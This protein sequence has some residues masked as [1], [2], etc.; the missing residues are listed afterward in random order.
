MLFTCILY[1]HLDIMKASALL[2]LLLFCSIPIYG[3]DLSWGHSTGGSQEDLPFALHVDPEDNIYQL[4][5][6]K[7]T[8]DADPG[9]DTSWVNAL[10]EGD[11]LIQ[12]FNTDGQLLWA[13]HIGSI[14]NEIPRAITGDSDGNIWI[15]GIFR[16]Q[17]DVDPGVGEV[18]LEG[19]PTWDF[20]LLKL[21]PEGDFLWAHAFTGADFDFVNS[22]ATDEDGNVFLGGSFQSEIDFDPG[23]EEQLV[24]PNGFNNLF[25]LKLDNEGNFQWVKT[26]VGPSAH[27]LYKLDVDQ[28]G[29][30]VATGRFSGTSDFDPGIPT[31]PLS[32]NGAEDVFLIKLSPD[33]DLEWAFNFGGATGDSG[34]DLAIDQEGNIYLTGY[35]T[36]LVDFDPGPGFFEFLSAGSDDIFVCKFTP[37][38]DFEWAQQIGG[39]N[40]DRGLSIDVGNLGLYLYL[41]G[42]FEGAMD[43]DPSFEE[44]IIEGEPNYFE[45]GFLMQLTNGP[46]LP[47]SWVYHFSTP[48]LDQVRDVALSSNDNWLFSMGAFAGTI[49]LELPSSQDQTIVTSNGLS[50]CFLQ[51]IYPFIVSVEDWSAPQTSITV[52][53]NPT[54]GAIQLFA[55]SSEITRIILFNASG[56]LVYQLQVDPK[57]EI[58]VTLPE[59][60]GSYYLQVLTT[61]GQWHT[62]KVIKQ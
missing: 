25:I 17:L 28:E 10:G 36:Q 8:V 57:A 46:L 45:D 60:N 49:N 44:F 51:G 31:L 27:T 42:Q 1:P 62:Q 20:F 2:T 30:V 33:G 15:T 55:P 14:D 34:Q 3:Q 48:G 47:L 52:G 9:S 23:V 5:Y 53:P 35:F 61:D 39:E 41:G 40:R 22:V 43:A 21:D 16:N 56:Q 32:S 6:F 26:V 54:G 24:E 19:N 29:N 13:R 18:L 50:D 7:D 37:S 38:G 58:Q 12:K 11:I 4:S 59:D